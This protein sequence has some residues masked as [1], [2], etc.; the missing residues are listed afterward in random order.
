MYRYVMVLR[1]A[2]EVGDALE[3]HAW[4]VEGWNRDYAFFGDPDDRKAVTALVPRE[5]VLRLYRDTGAR[6]PLQSPDQ[7]VPHPLAADEERAYA[8]F[9]ALSPAARFAL[10]PAGPGTADPQKW[11]D[12]L[13][14][15][16]RIAVWKHTGGETPA[17]L[18]KL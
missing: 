3:E 1:T 10:L 8:W 15:E 2:T 12:S 6:P 4:G 18:L 9:N 14:A 7:G 11:W 13:H 17:Y 5:V 16:Q